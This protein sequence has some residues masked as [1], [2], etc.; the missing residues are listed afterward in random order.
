MNALAPWLFF[1]VERPA[2]GH[3]EPLE[4][5]GARFRVAALQMEPVRGEV[6]TNLAKARELILRDNDSGA[7]LIVFPEMG[8]SGYI[9]SSSTEIMPHA[10]NCSDP[11]TQAQWVALADEVGAWLVIGHPAYDALTTRLTN[12]C[13]LVSPSGVVGHYDKTCLFVEDHAWATAGES[14]PPIWDTPVGKVSPLICADMDYPEPIHSAVSRGAEIIVLP[15]AWVGEPAPSATWA[16]RAWEHRVPV[17]AADIQGTDQGRVFSGGSCVLDANGDVIS[18]TDY[19]EGLVGAYVVIPSSH[20][21][22]SAAAMTAP[23]SVHEL[24]IPNDGR[25]ATA[26]DI[27][28]W[29]EGF[30]ASSAAPGQQLDVP[31]VIALPTVVNPHDFWREEQSD[32]ATAQSAVVVQGMRFAS[33]DPVETFI[34]APRLGYFSF[35]SLASAPVAAMVTID[36]VRLAIMANHD[37]STHY[38]SRALSF[39]GASVIVGQ[40]PHNLRPPHGFSG[41]SAPFTHGLGDADPSFGHP[42]RFRAGDANVWFGFHSDSPEVPSGIFSPDHVAWPRY[43]T[44][45]SAAAPLTQRCSLEPGDHWGTQALQKPL[46]SASPSAIYG[47]H[48]HPEVTINTWRT[49]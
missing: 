24:E 39:L 10:M 16:L 19:D 29:A 21:R 9:W 7:T 36:A 13:T 35:V 49:S 47:N 44:I 8:L 17:I 37:L 12:R 6:A 31:H 40:G 1:D 28:L 43:E 4:P 46:V 33:D 3:D 22:V 5:A 14:I 48:V 32:Y 26:M 2:A 27:S 15:T 23:L 34:F 20:S 42:V 38:V 41:S 30:P 25:V 18:A 11:S 45:A